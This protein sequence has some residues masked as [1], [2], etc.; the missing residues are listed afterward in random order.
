MEKTVEVEFLLLVK[1]IDVRAKQ[2]KIGNSRHRASG[3]GAGH[4]R[5]RLAEA[6]T[7]S[8]GV[9][10]PARIYEELKECNICLKST[11]KK[12]Q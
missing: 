8:C 6:I 11:D 2:V 1:P 3:D 5:D 9:Q 7:V 12:W 4:G 10:I